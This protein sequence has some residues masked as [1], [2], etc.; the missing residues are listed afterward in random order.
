[1]YKKSLYKSLVCF[2]IILSLSSCS[3]F[4]IRKPVVE[5]GNII[6]AQD[7]KKLSVG[8]TPS[9]V[10]EIMGAPVLTN[11]FTSHRMEY[12]YTYDNHTQPPTI[13]RLTCL[14]EAGRLKEILKN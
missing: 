4:Q 2:L 14:F 13:N 1:M 10:T 5:Q 12:V 11:I 6:T 3:F 8:M 7:A 9:Q